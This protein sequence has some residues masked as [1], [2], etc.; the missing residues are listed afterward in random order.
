MNQQRIYKHLS[1]L[2]RDLYNNRVKQVT[3]K[4]KLFTI[5]HSTRVMEEF[6]SLL[7]ESKIKVLIDIRRFPGSRRFPHF[8]LESLERTLPAVGETSP[9]GGPQVKSRSHYTLTI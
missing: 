8:S 6:L 1:C 9:S 7:N 2:V 5:G 4:I 3:D